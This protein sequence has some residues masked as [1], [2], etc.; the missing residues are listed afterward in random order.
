MG[1]EASAVPRSQLHVAPLGTRVVWPSD[2][3]TRK[4]GTTIR[5]SMWGIFMNRGAGTVSKISPAERADVERYLALL[6]LFIFPL[7]PLG[8]CSS[9]DPGR[10]FP[11]VP[12]AETLRPS[13]SPIWIVSL[14]HSRG[15]AGL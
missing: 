15:Q 12:L 1:F 7:S 4:H 2:T 6:I 5:A 9:A 11:P 8:N 14:V 13:C 3:A 10:R